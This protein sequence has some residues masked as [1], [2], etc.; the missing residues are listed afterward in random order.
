MNTLYIGSFWIFLEVDSMEKR[1]RFRPIKTPLEGS[2]L[3]M[4]GEVRGMKRQGRR[5]LEPKG[6]LLTALGIE[7]SVFRFEQGFFQLQGEGFPELSQFLNL[8]LYLAVGLDGFVGLLLIPV[9][10]RVGEPIVET[11]E[12]LRRFG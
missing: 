5:R 1:I 6:P 10:G 9:K 11:I 4:E 8:L 7:R 2:P 3:T 12:L